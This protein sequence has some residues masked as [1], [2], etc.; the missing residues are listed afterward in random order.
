MLEY[1]LQYAA[2][3]WPVF[4][5]NRLSKVP[6]KDSA[7]YKDA[8]VD[9]DKIREMWKPDARRNI[10]LASGREGG[11]WVLDLD[12]DKKTGRHGRERLAELEA[13]FGKLPDAPMQKTPSGGFHIFFA[14]PD[15]GLD[16]PRSIRFEEGMD[17]LG[18]RVEKGEVVGGYLVV[19][20]SKRKDGDYVWVRSISEID[21]P[22]APKWLIDKIRIRWRKE[23]KTTVQ[24]YRPNTIGQTSPYGRRTLINECRRV[25]ECVSGQH[26][27]LYRA[28][29]EIGNYIAGGEI[30]EADAYP[31]LMEASRQ[32]ADTKPKEPWKDKDRHR[33]IVDGLKNGMTKPKSAPVRNGYDYIPHDAETGEIIEETAP[34]HQD[35]PDSPDEKMA[36]PE[37]EKKKRGRP[38]K[39]PDEPPEYIVPLSVNPDDWPFSP[40]GHSKGA[41]YYLS[42]ARQEI[43]ELEGKEHSAANLITLAPLDW[44]RNYFQVSGG[45]LTGPIVQNI[46][47]L[48]FR[49]NERVGYFDARRVRGR[50]AWLDDGRVVVNT[51]EIAYVNGE[52]MKPSRVPGRYIYEG[53]HDWDFYSNDPS[54]NAEANELRKI[55]ESFSWEESLSGAL[56]AGWCVIAPVCGVLTWRPHIWITGGF[57][58]GKSTALEKVVEVML[59]N[60]AIKFQGSTTEAAIRQVLR[61]DARAIIFD[62]A[63]GNNQKMMERMQDILTLARQSSSGGEQWRGTASQK[64]MSFTLRACFCFSSINPTI[65]QSADDSRICKL[66]LRID[67][68]PDAVNKYKELERRITEKITPEYAKRMFARTIANLDVLLKNIRTFTLVA[69]SML[70]SKRAADQIGAMLA[71]T[72]LCHS[73]REITEEQAR[74]FMEK[75]SWD[76]YVQ[77][78]K[79]QDEAKLLATLMTHRMRVD[80]NNGSKELSIGSMIDRGLDDDNIRRA[81]GDI[82]IKLNGGVN[83]YIANK[84]TYIEG[85][86]LRGTPWEAGWQRPLSTIPGSEKV[87]KTTHF[88]NGYVAKAVKL[89]M[90][91]LKDGVSA[92]DDADRWTYGDADDE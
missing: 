15:D 21:P 78:D 35:D 11:F 22:Q 19:A 23:E 36:E 86:V 63:E 50:G 17:A 1:A 84:S 30:N 51:G 82:G 8:T 20:P 75:Y 72:F 12:G 54:G 70:G 4:A 59:K 61:N 67:Q 89:P 29:S 44:W 18:E 39:N 14:W 69:A 3:G 76:E 32:M 92:P 60:A 5:L 47:S 52:A 9:H 2:R 79:L 31:A 16:L 71:G 43:V 73:T 6:I 45:H 90:S 38:K 74:Q 13:E 28:S 77:T 34:P 49:M 40:L 85:T 46:I 56:L 88:A 64:A 62:E 65:K 80:T 33:T 42:K 41:F 10:A 55:C 37:Q 25:A 87:N 83:F 24:T 48:L 91:V 81:L 27:N 66:V 57:G 7:A 26:T 53:S 68:D 58:S